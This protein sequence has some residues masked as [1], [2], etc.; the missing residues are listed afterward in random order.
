MTK[1]TFMTMGQT[2]TATA[3]STN[4]ADN[5]YMGIAVATTTQVIDVL[6]ILISG[7]A[8][9]STVGAMNFTSI[10]T[11]AATLGALTTGTAHDGPN[12]AY[13]VASSSAPITFTAA[14]TKPGA[15]STT[16]ALAL[17]L[18]LNFFGGII[19]WNAAPT[20]Q[21]TI[22]GATTGTGEWVL[23]NNSTQ[24]GGANGAANAHIIYEPY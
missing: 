12:V 17:N 5:T 3:V 2:F 7:M 22:T 6:E 1:R 14:T 20:Q 11:T 19:R 24:G 10:N 16:T 9:A 15:T 23:Y 4:L 18:G 21:I 13:G 8:T